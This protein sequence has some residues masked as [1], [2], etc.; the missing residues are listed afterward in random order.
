MSA[1]D[2]QQAVCERYGVPFETPSQ[3]EKVGIA[4]ATLHL[5][6]LNGLRHRPAGGTCG[7][8]LWG[9]QEFSKA[10]DFFQPLHVHHLSDRCPRVL[11]YLALPPGYRFLVADGQEEV[12]LDPSLLDG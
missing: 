7:W 6:P 10:P 9:G 5:P 1:D 3:F 12:W 2:D 11:P 8:Y 4:L